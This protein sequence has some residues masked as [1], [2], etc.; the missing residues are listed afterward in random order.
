[1]SLSRNCF[2][3]KEGRPGSI[4]ILV[5]G[6]AA[7]MPLFGRTGCR[8]WAVWST[9]VRHRSSFRLASESVAKRAPGGDKQ[10]RNG[11]LVGEFLPGVSAA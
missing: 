2:P 6:I 10:H 7:G 11:T 4:P 1:M 3:L 8:A 9:K 5:T